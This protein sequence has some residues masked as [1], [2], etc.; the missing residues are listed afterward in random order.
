MDDGLK[1]LPC[2]TS[3]FGA[4]VLLSGLRFGGGTGIQDLRGGMGDGEQFGS[5]MFGKGEMD[6]AAAQQGAGAQGHKRAQE[7][8]RGET[9]AE[10]E[11]IHVAVRFGLINGTLGGGSTM[12]TAGQTG[13]AEPAGQPDAH[14]LIIGVAEEY[15]GG[16]RGGRR[17]RR[18]GEHIAPQTI[19]AGVSQGYP[20]ILGRDADRAAIEIT[21]TAWSLIVAPGGVE[22][23]R[24]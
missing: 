11:S 12:A 8:D 2:P 6:G 24:D 14:S 19:L 13:R 5:K 3:L 9:E 20:G 15:L 4:R 21:L 22:A 18:S 23:S 1:R 7:G 16:N 17:P 10:I